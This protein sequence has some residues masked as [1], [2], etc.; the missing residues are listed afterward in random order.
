V[1]KRPR[2]HEPLTLR[3]KGRS[4]KPRRLRRFLTLSMA[5]AFAMGGLALWHRVAITVAGDI[6]TVETTQVATAIQMTRGGEEITIRSAAITAGGVTATGGEFTA[7]GTAGILA[8]EP[9]TGGE[10]TMSGGFVSTVTCGPCRLYGDLYPQPTTDCIVELGDLLCLLDGYNVAELCPGSD[11]A[12]CGGDGIVE[13]AD[14]LA[15]LDAYADVY[16]CGHPC[17]P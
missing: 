9:M 1:N 2:S 7:V 4:T 14:L 16:L 6:D 3:V 17:P 13:L 10:F 15:I 8:G 12:P 5:M 11:I